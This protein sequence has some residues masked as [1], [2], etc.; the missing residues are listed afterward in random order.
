MPDVGH[1]QPGLFQDGPG[2]AGRL[3][4]FGLVAGVIAAAGELPRVM[5]EGHERS[6]VLVLFFRFGQAIGLSG[7]ERRMLPK[8]A[9]LAVLFA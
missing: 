6:Q 9:R 3:L 2:Q 8:K 7:D 1:L 5:E 4:L